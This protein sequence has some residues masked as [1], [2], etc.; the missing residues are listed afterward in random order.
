M[1]TMGTL[2]VLTALQQ[3]LWILVVMG[4]CVDG[5]VSVCMDDLGASL[6]S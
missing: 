5:E 6:G 1:T 2:G 3:L 4:I